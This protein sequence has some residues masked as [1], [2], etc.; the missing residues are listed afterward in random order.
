M[1]NIKE[2]EKYIKEQEKSSPDFLLKEAI[3]ENNRLQKNVDDLSMERLRVRRALQV[4]DN[5]MTYDYIMESIEKS[6]YN[7][8]LRNAWD[9]VGDMIR[10]ELG[11]AFRTEGSTQRIGVLRDVQRMIKE[12]EI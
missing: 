5:K 10:E 3:K 2:A 6:G 11:G 4:P 8:S 12:L 1:F 7:I 9:G